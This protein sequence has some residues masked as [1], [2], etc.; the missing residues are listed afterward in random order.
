M[1]TKIKVLITQSVV[2]TYRLPFFRQLIHRGNFDIT[3]L[4]GKK[5]FWGPA[6]CEGADEIANLGH[7]TK[8][9]FG[10]RLFWQE[11]LWIPKHFGPGDILVL[12]GAP[13]LLNNLPLITQAR[14]KK[15]KVV[16]WGQGWSVGLRPWMQKLRQ[17]LMK[18]VDV[19]ILY[20]NKE[21][22]EYTDAGFNKTRVFGLNNTI[23]TTEIS[24]Q[25][26]QWNSARLDE[27]QRSCGF[28]RPF[29]LLFVS[30]LT[31]NKQLNIAIES[32]CFLP[33]ELYE[34]VVIGDGPELARSQAFARRRGVDERV[35]WLGAIYEEEALAPYFM[36]ASCFVFPGAIGLSLLHA[37]AYGLPVVTHAD[38]LN[39]GPEFAALVDGVN[40]LTFD[41]SNPRSLAEKILTLCSD[42]VLL[43]SMRNNALHRI[44]NDFSM[45][46]MVETFENAMHCAA[47]T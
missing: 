18:L 36:T 29:R 6:S 5:V 1:S 24:V 47:K 23:D 22:R 17:V 33:E 44:K 15:M 38:A 27:H 7:E 28:I 3:I 2:P 19:V 31:Q 35:H 45:E 16:W 46:H 13:R 30:R 26:Q 4:A 12:Q 41:P 37:F 8:G 10:K 32:L 11:N 14:L 40:G 43:Q 42:S 39:H 20:T 21:V 34:L 25:R 9:F